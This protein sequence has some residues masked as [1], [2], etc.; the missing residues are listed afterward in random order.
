MEI[1]LIASASE[2]KRQGYSCDVVA[3]ASGEGPAA[4]AMRAAGYPLFHIPF[5]GRYRFL[6]RVRFLRDFYRLCRS[7]YD[8]VH[9]HVETATALF[10]V[11]ALAAGSRRIAVTPHST[12]RFTGRV[13]LR[14]RLERWVI[15]RLGG[16]YGMISESV[17]RCEAEEFGNIGVSI[18]NW[19][20]TEYFRPPSEAE[21][22]E[23]RRV[24]GLRPE[25]VAVVSVGNCE[26]VKNH[27]S[28]L[29]AL[30]QMPEQQRP[31]YVHVGREDKGA[32]E[33]A[34][35]SALG[36]SKW[37]RFTG[38]LAD[39]R[40]A[41]WAADLY[42]MPSL[43]EGF[44]LAAVEAIACGV[45]VVLAKVSGLADIAASI[46][47]AVLTE[48]TPESIEKGI[49]AALSLPAD[50]RRS[51]ALEDSSR[52]RTHYSVENGVASLVRNLYGI[53]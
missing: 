12:F 13:R 25:E 28:L 32:S 21:R 9:I 15:R 48:T 23:A 11:I 7:K 18:Q 20:D 8:V 27:G 33:R 19:I 6:P 29:R 51:R 46:K 44:T 17:R 43:R 5:R 3:I 45:P 39:V 49:T 36:I 1:M 10:A 53:A 2:W 52:V 41:L 35:V 31:T 24:A 40:P 26:E 42:V 47:W 16:R 4:G 30:A 14:K 37:V 22:A 34:L 50:E 38:S